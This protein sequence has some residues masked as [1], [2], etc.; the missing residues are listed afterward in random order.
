MTHP[1]ANVTRFVLSARE[2]AAAH[3]YLNESGFLDAAV[4]RVGLRRF[5]ADVAANMPFWAVCPHE[6]RALR[7]H[8]FSFGEAASGTA[9]A[10]DQEDF[11]VVQLQKL[12]Q[13]S[14]TSVLQGALTALT[15]PLAF[16]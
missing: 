9:D 11:D 1:Q 16:E 4:Y 6:A 14:W 10:Q 3:K 12:N 7:L 8:E 2:R 5:K 15:W 13:K